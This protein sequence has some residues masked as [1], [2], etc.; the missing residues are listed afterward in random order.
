MVVVV[1]VCGVGGDED[2]KTFFFVLVSFIVVLVGVIVSWQ[3]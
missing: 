2:G 1:P 3:C